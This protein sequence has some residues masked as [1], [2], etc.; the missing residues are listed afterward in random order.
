MPRHRDILQKYSKAIERGADF[1]KKFRIGARC[2]DRHQK[3]FLMRNLVFE[4]ETEF[5][6]QI[7]HKDIDGI[8]HDI[9][10]DSGT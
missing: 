8:H 3:D 6:G 1:D 5:H 9:F 7:K 10:D 4:T 2:L